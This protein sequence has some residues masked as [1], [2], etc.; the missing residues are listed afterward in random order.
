MPGK[1]PRVVVVTRET[2]YQLLLARHGTRAQ[3]E[4][5]LKSR[6]QTLDVALERHKRFEGAL[7]RVSS[8]IPVNWRRSRV[9]RKD[10]SRFLFEPE[11]TIV[12]V[13]RDGLVANTAKYLGGQPVIGI[14]PDPEENVGILVPF[15][16]EAFADFLQAAVARRC[17][18]Q[19]RTMVQATLNGGQRLL[20]LNEVFVGCRTHQSARY[21]IGHNGDQER[22]SSS[23]VI[24]AS[25]TGATGWA[26]SIH[27][28]RTSKVRLPDP[29]DRQ[30][31]FYV[32]EAFPSV[33]TQ[34]GL[35]Q[36]LLSEAEML[37]LTSEMNEG[38]VL[39]GD[40]IEEDPLIFDWGVTAEIGIAKER[41]HLV[42]G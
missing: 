24:V 41:L 16:P 15:P 33:A 13:G 10:L 42:V 2:E 22:H 6:N 30:L 17:A 3:A 38:G 12:V 39:F 40:G 36:G 37:T 25:G 19:D 9:D 29:E 34:V 26:L 11:D 20:A 14:N 5:F 18:T 32:R 21:R 31:A 1:F 7:K 8:R 27:R 35:T 28:E 4:F 23:G